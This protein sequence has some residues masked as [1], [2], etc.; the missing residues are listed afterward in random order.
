MA[1]LYIGEAYDVREA[2]NER[3]EVSLR[4]STHLV[5]VLP[6]QERMSTTC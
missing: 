1:V 4:W 6:N 2:S 5:I 3:K